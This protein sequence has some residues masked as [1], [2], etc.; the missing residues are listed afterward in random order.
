[1]RK[2]GIIRL[3]DC[4]KYIWSQRLP[5]VTIGGLINL[6]YIERIRSITK[7]LNLKSSPFGLHIP[8]TVL[9]FLG[10]GSVKSESLGHY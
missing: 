2:D 10:Q 5:G 6:Y 4:H 1:M 9:F 7:D 8:T 3:K